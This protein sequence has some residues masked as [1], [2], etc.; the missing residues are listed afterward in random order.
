MSGTVLVTGDSG[1]LAAHT[2]VQLLEEGYAVRS[3][4]RSLKRAPAVREMVAAGGA[5]SG[6]RLTLV[7]GDLRAEAGW[8]VAV[9]GVDN[10]LHM[11]SP[12]HLRCQGT[13]TN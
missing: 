8:A 3:T 1:F 10:V 12:I 7:E 13:R 4:V 2:I 9:D 11:A 6:H 5:A